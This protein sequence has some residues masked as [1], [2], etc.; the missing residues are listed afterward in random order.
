MTNDKLNIIHKE[1]LDMVK[2]LWLTHKIKI[3][4]IYPDWDTPTYNINGTYDC[5]CK[6]IRLETDF[7]DK[8]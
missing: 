5:D 7:Y 2:T 1:I 4:S 8:T 6:S 3:V